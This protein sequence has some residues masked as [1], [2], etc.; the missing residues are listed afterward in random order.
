MNIIYAASYKSISLINYLISNDNEVIVI[1][2]N[3]PVLEYCKENN[4]D[5][6][7]IEHPKISLIKHPLTYKAFLK[8]TF[9][10]INL[11]GDLWFTHNN[12]DSF[13]FVL[14]RLYSKYGYSV[15]WVDL[16][17]TIHSVKFHSLF[18]EIIL[19]FPRILRVVLNIF[20]F[21]VLFDLHLSPSRIGIP[22]NISVTLQQKK[23]K[24]NNFQNKSELKQKIQKNFLSSRPLS[25][26]DSNTCILVWCWEDFHKK[27]IDKTIFKNLIEVLNSIFE[28]VEFKPHPQYP[29]KL[30]ENNVVEL[31]SFIPA[32]DLIDEKK[33]VIGLSSIV[34]ID[35]VLAGCKNVFSVIDI[36]PDIPKEI[37]FDQKN[38]LM[39]EMLENDIEGLKFISD[40]DQLRNYCKRL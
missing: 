20:Y 37:L 7:K 35:S 26:S 16:D 11:N 21:K 6:K 27:Y 30:N 36:F 40:M 13:G 32:L 3:L 33:V 14:M 15:N 1:S 12:H 24:K 4:I 17:P 25:T 34:L 39:S 18:K 5:N 2:S 10:E 19:D 31:P 38:F 29:F 28:N 8:K 23:S 9:A 22:K